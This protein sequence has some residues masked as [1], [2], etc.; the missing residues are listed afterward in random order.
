MDNIVIIRI[1]LSFLI[2]GFAIGI[3][4]ILAERYSKYGG[5]IISIPST[6]PLS[7]FFISNVNGEEAAHISNFVVP[8]SL[9]VL[10]IFSYILKL[11]ISRTKLLIADVISVIIWALLVSI[12][13]HFNL[14]SFWIGILLFFIVLT[15]ILVFRKGITYNQIK[16]NEFSK[17]KFIL[18]YIIGGTVISL[19][20]VL[21]RQIDPLL[22]GYIAAFPVSYLININLIYASS[23]KKVLDNVFYTVPQGAFLLILFSITF[24]FLIVMF[25]IY[26]T[27]GICYLINV[28]FLYFIFRF[29]QKYS[30]ESF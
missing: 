22:G 26:V 27:M 9:I 7:L 14:S 12:I 30:K 3:Q 29:L 17:K 20:V 13:W 4:S 24:N 1:L 2:G 19:S 18:R 10:V 8:F 11:L 6:L 23:G 21:S 5:L 16:K 15:I 25:N 28:V